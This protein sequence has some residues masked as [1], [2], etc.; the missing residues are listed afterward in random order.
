MDEVGKSEKLTL[1][2]LVKIGIVSTYV[3]VNISVPLFAIPLSFFAFRALSQF[4]SGYIFTFIA[5]L[6]LII[7]NI[8]KLFSSLSSIEES[9]GLVIISIIIA[10]QTILALIFTSKYF[11]RKEITVDSSSPNNE[12]LFSKAHFTFFVVLFI[13]IN[14]FALY[15]TSSGWTSLGIFVY[16]I[17]FGICTFLLMVFSKLPSV[18]RIPKRRFQAFIIL[19]ILSYLFMFGDGGDMLGG[20]NLFLLR[21]LEGFNILDLGQLPSYVYVLSIALFALAQVYYFYLLQK[22]FD[23]KEPPQQDINFEKVKKDN[24]SLFYMTIAFAAFILFLILPVIIV[25]FYYL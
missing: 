21:L 23:T 1:P 5:A 14:P 22:T 17:F 4:R 7:V 9:L 6:L 12:Y 11:N 8:P 20:G 19:Q 2:L 24:K 10:I 3:L 13:L 15:G 16:G 25:L 18:L